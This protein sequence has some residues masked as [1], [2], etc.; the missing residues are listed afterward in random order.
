MKLFLIGNGFDLAH[1]MKTDYSDF[2]TFLCE[3]YSITDE[4]IDNIPGIPTS[5]ITHDGDERYNEIDEVLAIIQMLD[6]TGGC[7]WKNIET[8][9]AFLNYYNFLYDYGLYSDEK[10]DDTYI[11]DTICRNECNSRELCGALYS[12]NKYF[13]MWVDNIKIAT[14]PLLD[15]KNLIDCNKDLFLTFNYTETLEKLYSVINICHIHGSQNN[16][17]HFGH[18]SDSIETKKIQK[19]FPGAEDSIKCLGRHLKKDTKSAYLNNLNFFRNLYS[20]SQSNKINIYSYGFSFSDVDKIYL[21]NIFRNIDTTD[22]VFY[23]NDFDFSEKR[24]K[25]SDTIYKS[26]F[27]GEI[28]SFHIN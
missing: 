9:L 25:F 22:T 4:M 6:A 8:K 21:E 10:E 11:R 28:P 1:K 3:E 15:F 20:L 19:L 12:I 26:G 23:L 14:V 2:R 5:C 24:K 16:E 7:L 18:G 17:I 13:K 27:Q